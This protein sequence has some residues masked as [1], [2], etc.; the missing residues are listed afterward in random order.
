[1][2]DMEQKLPETRAD[3][4]RRVP[5]RCVIIGTGADMPVELW[6]FKGEDP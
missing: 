4:E 6:H 2:F 1:M 3:T 5:Q